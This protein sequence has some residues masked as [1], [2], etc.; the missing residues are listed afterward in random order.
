VRTLVLSK[1]DARHRLCGERSDG[2]TE[3][4]R[5]P[6]QRE[7]GAMVLLVR[8]EIEKIRAACLGQTS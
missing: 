7:H 2:I 8:V 1:I 4:L 5:R 6:C 3:G